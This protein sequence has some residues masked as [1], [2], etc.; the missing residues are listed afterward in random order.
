MNWL[1]WIIL[2]LVA[3]A[4]IKGFSR[5]FIVE[6]ASLVAFIAAVWAGIHLSER[7]AKAVGLGTENAALTFLVT[8]VLVLVGVHLLARGLTTLVDIAQLSLPNKFGGLFFGM[9]RSVFMLSVTL[10]LL[11][12]Y[13]E[14]VMPPAEARDGSTL[15]DP[16]RAFAPM[17]VPA[18]ERTEWVR[19]AVDRARE[20]I[21]RV[22]EGSDR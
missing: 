21:D 15:F 17:L 16:V 1:D 8:F 14:G 2:A 12:G 9:I 18:L 22:I 3:Y 13:S 11:V 19:A 10:N 5:G 20:E 6:L 4:G 7:V